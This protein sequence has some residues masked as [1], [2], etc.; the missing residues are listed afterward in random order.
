MTEIELKK[1]ITNG[2]RIFSIKKIDT[3]RDGGTNVLFTTES[4]FF[5]HKNNKTFHFSYPPSN[6]NL[7]TNFLLIKYLINRIER[8]IERQENETKINKNLLLEIKNNK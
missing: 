7:I 3:I 8:H 5:I 6:E 2:G 1:Y 4:D